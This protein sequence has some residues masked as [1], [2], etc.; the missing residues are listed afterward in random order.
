MDWL[1]GVNH[2]AA[3]WLW[4]Y[5]RLIVTTWV[6]VLLV[7]Y[8]DNIIR[9]VKRIMKPYHYSLRITAFILLCGFGFGALASYGQGMISY[10]IEW[11]DRIWFALIV[12]F[13]YLLLGFLA[14]RKHKT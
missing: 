6:A 11:I 2:D 5:R 14:E 7:L 9:L 13:A 1:L 3:D 4:G 8:G 10:L 12:I